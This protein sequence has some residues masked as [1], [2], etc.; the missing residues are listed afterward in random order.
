MYALMKVGV[1]KCASRKFGRMCMPS[2]FFF[3]DLC[4][5]LDETGGNGSVKRPLCP[6]T[7]ET[8]KLW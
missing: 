3:R 1:D 2:L 6:S 8:V 5:L 4:T 7:R